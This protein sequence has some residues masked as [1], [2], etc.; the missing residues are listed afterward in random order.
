MN[1]YVFI[2]SNIAIVL[3]GRFL[4]VQDVPAYGLI[5]CILAF[6]VVAIRRAKLNL[7]PWLFGR[8]KDIP[9]YFTAP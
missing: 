3:F 8:L 6:I 7:K 9:K 1:K 4:Q 5:I 2:L